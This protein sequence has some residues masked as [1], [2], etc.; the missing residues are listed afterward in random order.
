M[1]TL[2]AQKKSFS[3][4][5]TNAVLKI[6]IMKELAKR[7]QI[8][9][10]LQLE[11]GY[12][13]HRPI[14]KALMN[15]KDGL[16][17]KRLVRTIE[18]KF[19]RTLKHARATTL[20]GLT[21]YGLSFILNHLDS[22]YF[23]DM[24]FYNKTGP[25][26]FRLN[27]DKE[28]ISNYRLKNNVKFSDY[29]QSPFQCTDFSF[30]PKI[31]K[32]IPEV[33]ASARDKI[34][35]IVGSSYP[36]PE[37]EV[38][39][40]YQKQT[41]DITEIKSNYPSFEKAVIDGIINDLFIKRQ[42]V[43]NKIVLHLTL[44]GL[45]YSINLISNNEINNFIKTN[46]YLAPEILGEE[47]IKQLRISNPEIIELFKSIYFKKNYFTDNHYYNFEIYSKLRQLK[48][49]EST[50]VI[51][52]FLKSF[53][54][55]LKKHNLDYENLPKYIK[56]EVGEVSGI[57]LQAYSA[58]NVH[59][60]KMRVLFDFYLAYREIYHQNWAKNRNKIKINGQKLGDW[61]DR[62]L[63]DLRDFSN[64]EHKKIL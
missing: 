6:R 49:I 24:Y 26:R 13:D 56:S 30:Y 48:E 21:E 40:K 64:I 52:D 14:H 34:I 36:E 23:W 27:V 16:I 9:K 19:H 7:V 3:G 62:C 47:N 5:Q 35:K 10:D 28:T 22:D 12:K 51:K 17:K 54:N 45:I 31:D 8:L 33:F 60:L 11:L 32:L 55:S 43:G 2:Q 58:S 41:P 4:V 59:G 15:K 39:I 46:A 20:Y 1:D 57:S 53:T 44:L 61:H 29:L 42:E 37:E 38:I 25:K 63:Q 50:N 18:N